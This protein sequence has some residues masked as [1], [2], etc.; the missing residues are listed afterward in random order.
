MRF[1]SVFVLLAAIAPACAKTIVVN[2]G[3]DAKNALASVYTPNAVL[4]NV[5]DIV[6]FQFRGGNHTITQSSFAEPCTQQFNTATNRAGVTSGFV[7]FNN[8]TRRISTFS[9][10][11][12]QT[13]SPIWM[14]CQRQGHCNS[15]MA[16]SINAPAT[17]NT[18]AAFLAKAKVANAPGIGVT[19]PFTPPGA[20]PPVSSAT[21]TPTGTAPGDVAPAPTG[22]PSGAF[23]FTGSFS[24]VIFTAAAV[25]LGLT[26]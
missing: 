9:V 13:T 2:V 15:G 11:I 14:F 19:A 8:A 24:G 10:Q 23:K 20:T 1:F 17:G 6:Q 22:T 5:G 7:P 18:M 25:L 12:K 4:A 21:P 26:L 3:R 16:F